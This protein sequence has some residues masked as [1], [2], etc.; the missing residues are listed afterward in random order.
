MNP[1]V[2]T[3]RWAARLSGDELAAL[4]AKLDRAA[5]ACYRQAH[6]AAARKHICAYGAIGSEMITLRGE[7]IDAILTRLDPLGHCVRDGAR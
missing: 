2:P 6:R 1:T 7:A 3:D 5:D 4:A